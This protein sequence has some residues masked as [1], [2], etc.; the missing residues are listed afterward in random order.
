MV[1]ELSAELWGAIAASAATLS[2]VSAILSAGGRQIDESVGRRAFK[3]WLISRYYRH[4]P[5]M[6]GF[7]EMLANWTWAPGY[8]PR[9]NMYNWALRLVEKH[10]KVTKRPMRK[11]RLI[12]QVLGAPKCTEALS[13][14]RL[15]SVLEVDGATPLANIRNNLK[16]AEENASVLPAGGFLQC[17]CP[18]AQQSGTRV[19]LGAPRVPVKEPDGRTFAYCTNC[20]DYCNCHCD[21]CGD[22]WDSGPPGDDELICIAEEKAPSERAPPAMRN[23]DDDGRSAPPAEKTRSETENPRRSKRIRDSTGTRSN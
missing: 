19:C 3:E 15:T 21:G 20:V 11:T 17:A 16:M 6:H 2:D 13:R 18:D 22:A 8:D 10:S 9:Y 4:H 5:R 12:F 14:G 7:C 23:G 1:P